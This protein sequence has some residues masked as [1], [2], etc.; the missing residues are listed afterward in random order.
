MLFTQLQNFSALEV[1]KRHLTLLARSHS[2]LL[3]EA[4][5]GEMYLSLLE[6]VL[7]PHFSYL[8]PEFFA[9]DLPDGSLEAFL[10]TEL[11]E[12][13]RRGLRGLLRPARQAEVNIPLVEQAWK[14]LSDLV[15]KKFGWTSLGSLKREG[16]WEATAREMR[17]KGR[18][19][20]SYNLLRDPRD[21]DS[22]DGDGAG[23]EEDGED[24]PVVVEL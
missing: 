15:E 5:A 13:L 4:E 8:R 16:G 22:E 19:R 1:Y 3:A 7:I 14:R 2:V 9:E 11:S 12:H 24:A 20:V 18:T 17:E 10:L 6:R 21:S 23:Y